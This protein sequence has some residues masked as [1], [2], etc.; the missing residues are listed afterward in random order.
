M[1]SV[2]NFF[3]DLGIGVI[4]IG[5]FIFGKIIFNQFFGD[6]KKDNYN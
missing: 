2:M 6:K 5:L 4:V 1:Q 3:F